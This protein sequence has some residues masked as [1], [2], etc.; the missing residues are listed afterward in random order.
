MAESASTIPRLLQLISMLRSSARWSA[1]AIGEALGVSERTVYRDID[2][3]Q[4]CGFAVELDRATGG[5][6]LASECFL[7]PLDLTAEETV[8]LTLLAQR[9]GA[10][11][12]EPLGKPAAKAFT[13]LKAALPRAIRED[14]D[15]V[16]PRVRFHGA[17]TEP[18]S[19]DDV[20]ATVADSIAGRRSL[21]CTYEPAGG[22]GDGAH[23]T[24]FRFDPYALYFGQRAWYAIGFH[25][26]RGDLRSLKLV[27]FSGITRSDE[28][29]TI[30]EDF[31][32]EAYFG[33]AW[34]MIRGDERHA[35]RLRF[36]PVVAENV[37]DTRWHSTQDVEWHGDGSITVTFE[38]D[39]LGE[40]T[41]WILGYGP[42]CVVEAPEALRARVAELVEQ[43]AR[44]Y[45][46]RAE[47]SD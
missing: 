42:H 38:V 14:A 34:R 25:H 41:W 17:A 37:A 40:I 20:W 27:R 32:L 6:R 39:G 28:R 12:P 35:V 7:P 45:S 46:P 44:R 29:Y 2:R 4:S 31:S 23:E 16:A 30:P 33:R 1:P 10:A 26:G 24:P 11:E 3:L 15:E 8:A 22:T 9:A 13:K 19:A 47:D 18:G 21:E 5:Y 36:D 43:T